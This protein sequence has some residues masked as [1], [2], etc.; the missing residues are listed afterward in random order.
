MLNHATSKF[1]QVKVFK[2]SLQELQYHAAFGLILCIDAMEMIF[3]ED[4]PLVLGNFHQAFKTSGQL[5]F[6]VEI[7]GESVLDHD[8]KTALDQGLP[9]RSLSKT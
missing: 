5:Y 2:L 7:A 3:L 8:Y 1:P 6:T 4:C 9:V